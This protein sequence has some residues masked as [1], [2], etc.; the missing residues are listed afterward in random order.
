[1]TR[2]LA[3]T[4]VNRG[5]VP[6][7]VADLGQLG[8]LVTL[9]ANALGGCPA[10]VAALVPPKQAPPFV[11]APRKKLKLAYTVA[12]DCAAADP[13]EVELEWEASVALDALG[14]TDAVPA[15]DACP[16][17]AAGDDE[18][19]GKPPGSPIRTDVVAK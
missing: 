6:E 15:N 13:A 4:V 9:A 19:C 5:T 2:K 16:R 10:P 8:A 11:L 18:G 17:A 12:L 1:V 7:M 14:A 3:V